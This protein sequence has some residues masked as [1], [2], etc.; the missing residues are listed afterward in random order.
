MVDPD[1]IS[2][3]AEDTQSGCPREPGIVMSAFEPPARVV[4]DVSPNAIQFLLIADDVVMK[5][6]L[7]SEEGESILVGPPFDR[8]A[9]LRNDQGYRSWDDVL[10]TVDP[11][12][13]AAHR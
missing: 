6:A 10:I 9:E 7:P 12:I 13:T 4:A 11:A 1:S 8:T 5:R 3:H 2:V